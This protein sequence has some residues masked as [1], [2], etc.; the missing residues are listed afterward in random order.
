MRRFSLSLSEQQLQIVN[1]KAASLGLTANA[2]IRNVLKDS[3]SRTDADRRHRETLRAIRGLI[4]VLAEAF[5]RTQRVSHE[6][7]D[8]LSKALLE[9]YAQVLTDKEA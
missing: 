2:Y 1:Q 8:R 9:R 4:P 5:G 6:L 7:I 3:F